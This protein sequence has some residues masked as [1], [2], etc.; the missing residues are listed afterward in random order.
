MLETTHSAWRDFL[1]EPTLMRRAGCASNALA[2]A[3]SKEIVDNALDVSPAGIDV[4]CTA[5]ALIVRDFGPGLAEAK[6]LE[7]FAVNRAAISSK[8]WRMARRGALGNGLRVV[9]GVAHVSGGSL[10]VESRGVGLVLTTAISDGSARIAERFD[11]TIDEGTR[12]TMRIGPDLPFDALRTATYV[13]ASQCGTGVAFGGSKAVVRWFDRATIIELLH[14]VDPETSVMRFAREFDLE[15]FALK[16]VKTR[17]ARMTTRQLLDD[18]DRCHALVNIILNGG[19]DTIRSLK[20]MGRSAREGAYAFREGDMLLGSSRLPFVVEIWTRGAA[21]YNRKSTGTVRVGI[22]YTN[23][24][25]ALM[26]PS[27]GFVSPHD[28]RFELAV[29]GWSMT[30]PGILKGPCN[31]EIDIAITTPELPLISE[32]KQIDVEPFIDDIVAAIEATLKRAYVAPL[33]TLAETAEERPER[34]PKEPKQP[35]PPKQPHEKGALGRILDEQCVATGLAASELLVM[36]DGVDP[37]SLDTAANHRLGQW[38]RDSL[39]DAGVLGRVLHVRGCFYALVAHGGI[40]KPDGTPF[41]NT[42]KNWFY[43]QRI[44]SFA[45]WLGYVGWDKI[46]DERNTPPIERTVEAG[47]FALRPSIVATAPRIDIPDRFGN[48]SVAVDEDTG[49]PF[50]RQPFRLVLFGEKTGLEPVLG[51]IAERFGASLYL[52]SGEPSNTMLEQMARHG[53][54]DG[55]PMVVFTF[56]DFD[57]TGMGIPVNIARK[58]HAFRDLLY[59]GLDFSVYPLAMTVDQ[60]RTLALPSTPF[61]ESES[62]AD[63]WRARYGVEQTEIDALSALRPDVLTDIAI[64]AI[65]PFFDAT[66]GRR[67]DEAVGQWQAEADERLAEADREKLHP[68]SHDMEELA[69]QL[70]PASE[71]FNAKAKEYEAEADMIEIDYPDFEPPEPI[72]ADD[73]P[74]PLVSTS[75]DELEFID[76]LKAQRVTTQKKPK[77]KRN[78][79]NDDDDGE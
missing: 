8:R 65:S 31:F 51:P 70:R 18:Q 25:P 74:E 7:L 17:M 72:I 29:E 30:I 40:V 54:A 58:L 11:S 56:T 44:A 12:I 38:F 67:H 47:E 19:R 14:D 71:A 79:G 64:A 34:P 73:P 2:M 68:F 36:S 49:F 55:R 23:R 35:K 13:R 57:P 3:A 62:R 59:P 48:L 77:D 63:E 66:L 46:K 10:T 42:M 61:K 20:R 52:P 41:T 24:T 5:D 21:V 78:K 33:Y 26:R 37:Y 60:V 45:R 43:L 39:E 6:I 75:M 16:E 22:I 4:E 28:N 15:G 27:E 76:H 32:S 53:A 1:S 50:H 9:M 69:K